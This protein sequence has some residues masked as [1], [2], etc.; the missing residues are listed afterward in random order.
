MIPSFIH[1]CTMIHQLRQIDY[2]ISENID[3]KTKRS[4]SYIDAID[5]VQESKGM[6]MTGY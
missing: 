6:D 3:I 1:Y 5:E 2:E 4:Q